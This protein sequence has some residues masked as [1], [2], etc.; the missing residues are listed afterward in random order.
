MADKV[1]Y[2]ENKLVLRLA[3]G[4]LTK[5]LHKLDESCKEMATMPE[6]LP[7]AYKV[8]VAAVVN[9]SLSIVSEKSD[10]VRKC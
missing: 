3:K 2:D 8:R 7:M 10:E 4:Q 5:G 9:E 1:Q 6:E